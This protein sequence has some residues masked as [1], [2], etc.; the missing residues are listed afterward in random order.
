[1]ARTPI[2]KPVREDVRHDDLEFNPQ[3]EPKK[4]KAWLNLLQESEDAFEPWN[5]HCDRID[6]L[7][8]SL[9]RL[10]QR[11]RSKEFQMFWANME[12]IRPAIYAKPP[13]PVV[14]PKFSDRRPVY[15]AASEMLERCNV[16]AFDLAYINELMLQVR[17]D[18][19]LIGRGVVWCRYESGK[20]KGSYYDHEK[21]CFDF[22]CRRDFLHSISRSWP[23]VTW[24]AAASYLTRAEARDRFY[25]RSGDVYQDAEY[26]VDK[27]SQE[28]GGAD[29][30]ERAKFWEVWDKN[31]GRVVWVAQGCEDILDEDDPELDLAGFFPCP[32][33]AYGTLQ[34][35]SLVPVP[36][37]LQYRDQLEEIN[38]L[39]GRI[40]ALADV[41]EAKGFYPAGTPELSDAVEK[42]INIKTPGRVLVPISNWAAFGGTKEVIVWLPIEEIAA[43]IKS[44][45]EL[46]RQI[47]DDIYQ[48]VG[49][50]DIMRGSTDPRETYGAQNLKSQYGS[51]RVRD[52][53]YELVRLA[54]DLVCIT[55][56]I[57]CQ[58]F[59]D[60]TLIQMS[61][62]QLPTKRMQEQA[63]AMVRR[64]VDAKAQQFQQMSN[65]PQAQ[66]LKQSD[67]EQAQQLMASAQAEI[68]KGHDTIRKI[69]SRPNIDQVLTF[70]RDNRARAF[71]LDIETDSTIIVDEQAEKEGRAEYMGMLSQLLPQLT[72]MFM[73]DPATGEFCGQVLKFSTAPYRAGR[74][75]DGA[76]DDLIELMKGKAE[77]PRPDDPTTATNK[78]ALQ[79]EQ[80]KQQ[81]AAQKD[82]ADNAIKVAEL[83]KRDEWEKLKISSS[84]RIKVMELHSKQQDNSAK[85]M[86]AN[87][88]ALHDREAHQADMLEKA[89]D[90]QVNRQEAAM[91]QADAIAK[92]NDMAARQQE[93]VQAQQFRQMQAAQ[94]PVRPV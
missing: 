7:Y 70:L 67:P 15:Q 55:S 21:V 88:Q 89:A 10:A 77:G 39:T 82:Q 76:I 74:T 42:A 13:T 58:K 33:P 46:R 36:D 24:V 37:V 28:V 31:S 87:Q 38:T 94:R 47:I 57:M 93:R 20:G 27:D 86:Q 32:K 52:K 78:T 56:D 18:L 51:T 50:S 22:K 49:L 8:A 72:Q 35:Y 73:A 91:R 59:A 61:Q 44:C 1:M 83:K 43:V 92:R 75:L 62:T 23:E 71:T 11:G 34:R 2:K 40:H 85:A 5:D 66:Q 45:L 60:K 41:L 19:A 84:E 63:V 81:R 29:N 6:K 4:A 14:A 90:M 80:L 54:R 64:Q 16:V 68:Q 69:A 26:K 12:V 30:R 25:E 79:I 65:S 3:L 53:Q 9:E 48:I 17:D